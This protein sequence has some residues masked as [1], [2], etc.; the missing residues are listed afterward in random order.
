MGTYAPV[1]LTNVKVE[2]REKFL[3]LRRRTGLTQAE[4]AERSGVGRIKILAWE[5]GSGLLKQDQIDALWSA[6][7]TIDSEAGE[8]A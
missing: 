7:D 4:V 8:V 3:V 2:E 1:R 6:L 5:N